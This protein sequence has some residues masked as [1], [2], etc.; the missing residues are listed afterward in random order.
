MKYRKNINLLKILAL[1]KILVILFALLSSIT[2]GQTQQP[3]WLPTALPK[4]AEGGYLK[5]DSG[6]I[7]AIRDTN[8]KAKY[9]TIICS[10]HGIDTSL[11]F[12]KGNGGYWAKIGGGSL[13]TDIVYTDSS[14]GFSR[15]NYFDSV[16]TFA[17]TSI[18]RGAL[19]AGTF[20]IAINGDPSNGSW[21]ASN[22]NLNVVGQ[23]AS[24]AD[25]YFGYT[26]PSGLHNYG[27]DTWVGAWA[28]IG[29]GT[30]VHVNDNAEDIELIC[31]DYNSQ[32]IAQFNGNGSGFLANNNIQ[33]YNDGTFG[34]LTDGIWQINND[35]SGFLANNNLQWDNSGAIGNLNGAWQINN[36][37]S[38]E[39][40]WTNI[41]WNTNGDFSAINLSNGAG[42]G[43]L[44]QYVYIGDL[45]SAQTITTYDL[46][47]QT[48]TFNANNGFTFSGGGI[49]VNTTIGDF[50]DNTW[51]ISKN[52]ETRLARNSTYPNGMFAARTN[53]YLWF[54]DIGGGSGNGT[55]YYLDDNL[56][57]QAFNAANGFQFTGGSNISSDG[58]LNTLGAATFSNDRHQFLTDGSGF[59]S[60]GNFGWDAIGNIY[61]NG[62]LSLMSGNAGIFS[63]GSVFGYDPSTGVPTFATS[64]FGDLSM[65]DKSN[66][67]TTLYTGGDGDFYIAD[68]ISGNITLR[69]ISLGQFYIAD[70]TS[71]NQTFYVDVAGMKTTDAVAGSGTLSPNWLL[72]ATV[73]G[74]PTLTT[75]VYI[76][77]SINGIPTQIPAFQ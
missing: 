61:T 12:S 24:D 14:N 58:D 10:I 65:Q 45:E 49:N 41:N 21:D 26:V 27:S 29:N 31:Y 7:P 44:N 57:T 8:F 33:W 68:K 70:K 6:L 55:L 73:S 15:Y 37:G 53:G 11:Y 67:N 16:V 43:S 36:D 77:V 50:T 51:V 34:N 13:P 60:D 54:G 30:Q 19:G 2:Y 75:P 66:D 59:T 3:S 25:N 48:Q 74:A 40:S 64:G 4:F 20:G 9:P 23:I 47:N 1:R 22:G 63:D 38:G 52:G 5:N 35:G 28:E 62:Y 18:G 71:G 17:Y 32:P 69:T 56:Q 39:L 42:F 46:I 76:N 72:G